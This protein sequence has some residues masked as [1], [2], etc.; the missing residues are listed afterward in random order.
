MRSRWRRGGDADLH[1]ASTRPPARGARLAG[2]VGGV[3]SSFSARR[4][5]R[6][7]LPDDVRVTG[8]G[9]VPWAIELIRT[10]VL[11][12][13]LVTVPFATPHV[14]D[15]AQGIAIGV[16]LGVCVIA[17]IAWMRAGERYT[18]V[19]AAL[20]VLAAA[21]GTLAGLST[22]STAVAVGCVVTSAAGSRLEFEVSAALTARD[23]RGVPHRRHRGRRAARHPGRLP[24]RVRRAV[25]VRPDPPRIPAP[26]RAGRTG[27]G[28]GP[29]RARRGNAGGGAGRAGAH[30]PRDPRRARP[31][32]RRRVGE[33]P[34]RRGAARRAAR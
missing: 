22:F 20:A 11:V 14:G 24:G 23:G 4:A 18:A 16:A 10:L 32:P 25:G 7:C 5:P 1:P 30:R 15:G 29:P 13:V 6:T 8:P 34:G 17:W 12:M 33:P 26:R 31:L 27:P 19:V 3:F 9:Q 2:Y 21:G 28:T